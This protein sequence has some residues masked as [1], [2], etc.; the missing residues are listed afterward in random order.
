MAV[1]TATTIARCT[2]FQ[3]LKVRTQ[4]RQLELPVEQVSVMHRDLFRAAGIA[5]SDGADMDTTLRAV[6]MSAA[7]RLINALKERLE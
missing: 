4:L 7:S 5:W 6:S 2:S 1:E 3:R